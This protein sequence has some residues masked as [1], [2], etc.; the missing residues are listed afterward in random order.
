MIKS[1]IS[2]ADKVLIS[3]YELAKNKK[4]F[5]AEDLTVKSWE[6]YKDDF[7]L[8]GYKDH[9]NSNQIYTFLMNKNGPLIK[10]GWIKKIGQKQYK[11]SDSGTNYVISNLLN[12]KDQK[13]SQKVN[14][15][16]E[17]HNKI[18]YFLRNEV[19]QKILKSEDLNRVSFEQI[20]NFW[21]ISTSVT[22]PA[23]TEK[24]MQLDT[25]ISLLLKEFKSADKYI[26][27]DER[28]T[29]TKKQLNDF[30]KAQKFFKEKFDKEIDYIKKRRPKQVN[31]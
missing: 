30:L 19:S 18:S 7:C 21:G 17:A 16:R 8:M 26:N 1:K 23:L 5:S 27:F 31:N 13:K 11:I 28:I 29:L 15:L 9:P 25:W 6:L 24:F 20:C 22:Y 2:Q 14:I 10:N 4:V 3:A 12:N